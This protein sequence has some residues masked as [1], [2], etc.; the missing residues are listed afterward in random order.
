MGAQAR[1]HEVLGHAR[2]V[3]RLVVVDAVLGDDLDG[4]EH[5]SVEDADRDLLPAMKRSTKT[6]SS[7]ARARLDGPR[8]LGCVLGLGDADARAFAPRL[9]HDREA[10]GTV[11]LLEVGEAPQTRTRST[12]ASARCAAGTAPCS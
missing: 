9:D 8:E 11:D 3:L 12:A 4:A 5:A 7:K 2:R 6:L 1:R 10:E